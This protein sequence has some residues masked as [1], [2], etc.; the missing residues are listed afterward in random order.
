MTV[1]AAA[2]WVRPKTNN[3]KEGKE[4]ERRERE[5]VRGGERSGWSNFIEGI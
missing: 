3:V 5:V 4:R 2:E 1:D